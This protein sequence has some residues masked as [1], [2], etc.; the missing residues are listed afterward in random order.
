MIE[1]VGFLGAGFS[2]HP[3]MFSY[4]CQVFSLFHIVL[5]KFC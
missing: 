3:K 4:A 5:K 2:I 1:L